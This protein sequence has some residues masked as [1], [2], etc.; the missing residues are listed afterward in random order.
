[1]GTTLADHFNQFGRKHSILRNTDGY[2]VNWIAQSTATGMALA[3][4][5]FDD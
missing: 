2:S 3:L 1:M 4:G 5:P